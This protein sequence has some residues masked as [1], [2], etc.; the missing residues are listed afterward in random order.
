M[1]TGEKVCETLA[2]I[3]EILP[4]H[5]NICAISSAVN[6]DIGY[7][8][9]PKALTD[10]GRALSLRQQ[11]MS[12]LEQRNAATATD[13]LQLAY[14][15]NDN[16]IILIQM[17]EYEKAVPS[18]EESLKLKNKWADEDTIPWHF[19]ETYKNLAIVQLS[20]GHFEEAKRYATKATALCARGVGEKAASTLKARFVM[21]TVLLN[22]HDLSKALQLHKQV[23][24]SRREVFED[25]HRLTKDSFNAIAVW[26]NSTRLFSSLL[27]PSAKEHQ[28]IEQHK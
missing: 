11:R 16:G 22:C 24:A 18:F 21:A 13:A 7:S 5:A 2:H 4:I 27:Y 25:K 12:M 15:W 3:D 26:R 23:L 14:A 20:R 28:Y 1:D 10:T 6:L 8:G 9:R 17:G 19:G